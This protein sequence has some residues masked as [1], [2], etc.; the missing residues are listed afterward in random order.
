ICYW[1]IAGGVA[2]VA[3]APVVLPAL[4]FGAGGIAAGSLAA[5]AMSLAWSTGYGVGLVSAAQSAG[6]VGLSMTAKTAAAAA[7]AMVT[8]FFACRDS[9]E[10]RLLTRD[11]RTV[12]GYAAAALWPA[13]M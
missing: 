2:T 1:S 13:F 11:L 9:G 6:A 3:A 8:Q 4:G 5:K 7:G 10:S 12:V